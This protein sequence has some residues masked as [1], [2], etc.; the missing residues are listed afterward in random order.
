MRAEECVL[1]VANELRDDFGQ[2]D[3]EFLVFLFGVVEEELLWLE[4]KKETEE[5]KLVS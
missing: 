4:R 2:C 3:M 1:W 5:L